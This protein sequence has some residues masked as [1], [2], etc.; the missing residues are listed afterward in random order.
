MNTRIKTITAAIAIAAIA[1][2]GLGANPALANTA[3]DLESRTAAILAAHPGGKEI[4]PG[5]ISW[6]DGAVTLTLEGAPISPRSVAS[7]ATGQYCAWSNTSYTGT[8][9]TFT[10]CSSGG[11]SSSLALLGGHARSTAN[12][13]TSGHVDARAGS[14]TIYT[15]SAG[16]G[17]PSNGVTLT[18]LVCYT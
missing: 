9:L 15:M 13:R 11:T 2:L 6:N 1:L 17:N 5:I 16:T 18:A 14:T 4:A 10:A 3:D 12:A 8:K 7:C